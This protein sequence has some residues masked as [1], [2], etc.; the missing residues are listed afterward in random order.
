MER[1]PVTTLPALL[2]SVLLFTIACGAVIPETT[3]PTPGSPVATPASKGQ[4][5]GRAIDPC[6]VVTKEE[7]EAAAG[8]TLDSGQAAPQGALDLGIDG[9]HYE[10]SAGNVSVAWHRGPL[11]RAGYDRE[12]QETDGDVQEAPG[13]GDQAFIV[14]DWPGIDVHVLRGDLVLSIGISDYRERGLV[15]DEDRRASIMTLARIALGRL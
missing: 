6:S 12:R 8:F 5:A 10:A 4:A 2:V 7:A 9:C 11:A 3:T 1:L 14:V 13:L 15:S